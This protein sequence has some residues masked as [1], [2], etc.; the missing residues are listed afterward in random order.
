VN[1]GLL[2]RGANFSTTDISHTFCQIATKF[3]NVGDLVNRNFLP[4]F[5]ELW[6]AGPVIP[7]GD[8]HQFFI[9]TLVKWFFDKFPII[10]DSFIVLSHCVVPGLGA[11]FPYR[12]PTLHRTAF[13]AAARP[14]CL[15]L[16]RHETSLSNIIFRELKKIALTYNDKR[17]GLTVDSS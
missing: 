15:Y 7:C 12:C 16:H 13:P 2:L 1:F 4:E 14:S 17:A 6:S 11:S 5:H 10:A 8:M 9:D 3:G